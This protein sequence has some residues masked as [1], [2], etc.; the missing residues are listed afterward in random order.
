MNTINIQY[1][2]T[3]FG[4]LV[5]GSFDKKLCL[6]DWRYRT[7]RKSID[8]RIQSALNANYTEKKTPVI[9][10][11]IRQ[12]KQYFH[13]RRRH[14]TVPL[15]M[16]GTPFQCKVW[17]ELVKIPYGATI[18][19]SDLALKLGNKLTIRAVAAANG[20][21]ALSIFIPCHR[22]IGSDG[23]LVG[24]AGGLNAKKKLLELENP[25]RLSHQLDLF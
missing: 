17:D 18:S 21:N 2:K 8:D 6:C 13:H 22:V 25:A 15:L 23:D 5:L 24:Y 9:E 1:F 7:H 11:A 3:K 10:F 16:A 12:L 20:A 4:E 19:Y 14:F